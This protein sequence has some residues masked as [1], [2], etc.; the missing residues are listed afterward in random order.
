VAP[1]RWVCD[2]QEYF[3]LGNA[4]IRP[5]TGETV[6][7]IKEAA[8]GT[9]ALGGAYIVLQDGKEGFC[10]FRI[11]ADGYKPVWKNTDYFRCGH[12]PCTG[13]IDDGWFFSEV[14]VAGGR[15]NMPPGISEMAIGIELATGKVVGPVGFRGGQ[16]TL[17]TSPTGMDGRWFFFVG[18]GNS[19]LVMMNLDPANFKQVGLR[20][21]TVVGSV[22]SEET[23]AKFKLD[24]CNTSTPALANGFMYFRGSDCLWCYDVRKQ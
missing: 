8:G 5:K 18:A 1:L 6:W 11:G 15:A 19:G 14:N 20:M 9:P 22:K 21:T 4:C 17:V 16:Q 7:Q 23:K 2:G 13:V 3:I 24:F 10:C 12:M